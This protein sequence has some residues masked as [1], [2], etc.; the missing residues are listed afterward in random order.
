MQPRAILPK[1]IKVILVVLT[2]GLI[3]PAGAVMAG[4]NDVPLPAHYPEEF[5]AVGCIEKIG[6]DGILMADKDIRFA[7]KAKFYIR[8]NPN[9][10]S[11][12]NFR[13]GRKVGLVINSQQQIVS[14]WYLSRC[15]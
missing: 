3:S 4:Q 13:A 9:P 10:V 2:I 8:E 15:R 7:H 12:R 5:T 11:L 6:S 14:M 1:M